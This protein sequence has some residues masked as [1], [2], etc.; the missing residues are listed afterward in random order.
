MENNRET[1]KADQM[2]LSALSYLAKS[3]LV[4]FF[5]FLAFCGL[6]LRR[7]KFLVVSMLFLGI[8]AAMF[9]YYVAQTKFYQAS[10]IV[11]S[12]IFPKKNYAGIVNQLNV[13]AK[14]RS[15]DKLAAEM[16]LPE[17]VASNILSF[18]T[19]NM[20]EEELQ[21]DTTSKAGGPFQVLISIQHNSAVDSIQNAFIRYM[22][23]LP[24]IRGI[25]DVQKTS[26][27][28]RLES[29]MSDLSQMDT[30]KRNYNKSLI[31]SKVM[32]TMY[33]DAMDPSK[34]YAQTTTVL[35][36]IRDTRRRLNV[37]SVDISALSHVAIANTTRSKSLFILLLIL[38]PGGLLIG[39]LI[40]LMSETKRRLLPQ[41]KT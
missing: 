10:M 13:L 4:G 35:D 39:F 33:S 21:T 5:R 18:E 14:S 19:R 7:R 34:V 15:A 11:S 6:V 36:D 3:F 29:L 24:Y 9:Y 17:T 8:F 32:A 30:L 22:N 41:A 28:L 25:L 38:G 16:H 26:D 40:A 31:S 1:D 37:D 2:N 23:N 27:S 20:Q 12:N